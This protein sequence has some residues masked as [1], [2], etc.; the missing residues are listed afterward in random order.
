MS[1]ISLEHLSKSSQKVFYVREQL[2]SFDNMLVITSFDDKNYN[3]KLT[4]ITLPSEALKSTLMLLGVP[5]VAAAHGTKV[6]H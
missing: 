3:K 2:F 6:L 1:T 5:T 4:K